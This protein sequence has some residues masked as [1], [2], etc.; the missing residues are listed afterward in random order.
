[1]EGEK[2]RRRGKK[3]KKKLQ[4][5]RRDPRKRH[6]TAG[7]RTSGKRRMDDYRLQTTH[8]RRSG[9]P[10]SH[11]AFQFQTLSS[12]AAAHSTSRHLLVYLSLASRFS[13]LCSPRKSCF[14]A[15]SSSLADCSVD[16]RLPS[17]DLMIPS[18]VCAP[19]SSSLLLGPTP[20]PINT[21]RGSR[22]S[23]PD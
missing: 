13:G 6:S 2:G 16:P 3:Q 10:I 19:L 20:G 9:P 4:A 8:S 15:G 22:L 18:L 17:L 21:H 11:A 14:L 23:R 12:R 5:R 1:M 7:H